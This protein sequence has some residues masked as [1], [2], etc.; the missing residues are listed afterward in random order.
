MKFS[1]ENPGHWALV[2]KYRLRNL[3][4]STRDKAL[5]EFH[6][7]CSLGTY[8]NLLCIK[9]FASPAPPHRWV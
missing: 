5:I 4:V 3:G 7:D 2:V 1:S 9:P 8:L 6:A